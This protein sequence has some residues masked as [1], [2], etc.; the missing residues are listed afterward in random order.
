MNMKSGFLK[1]L[2]VVLKLH[3]LRTVQRYMDLANALLTKQMTLL[4]MKGNKNKN[5][6]GVN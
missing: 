1:C 3:L 5:N 6:T 4:R 2:N